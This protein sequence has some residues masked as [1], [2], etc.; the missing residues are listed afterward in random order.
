MDNV[1][2]KF[3]PEMFTFVWT[4][5]LTKIII[6]IKLSL[7][8]TLTL[9]PTLTLT[10]TLTLTPMQNLILIPILTLTLIPIKLS[11]NL[12]LGLGSG[13]TRMEGELVQKTRADLSRGA[14]FLHIIV[15]KKLA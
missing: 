7:G 14:V 2:L 5:H 10:L 15:L 6:I 4:A 8:L 13:V 9:T 1:N 12:S 3:I 11:L